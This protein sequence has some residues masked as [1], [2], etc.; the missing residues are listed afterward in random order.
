MLQ[1][2]TTITKCA[3]GS[4]PLMQ[5]ADDM[6]ERLTHLLL[7]NNKLAGFPQIISAIAV[8]YILLYGYKFKLALFLLLI[9]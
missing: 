1:S 7:A 5:L 9:F 6:G 8:S 4:Q 3:I 2:E